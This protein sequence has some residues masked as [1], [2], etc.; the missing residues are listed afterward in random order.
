MECFTAI[1]LNPLHEAYMYFIGCLNVCLGINFQHYG[2]AIG[3][4]LQIFWGSII[5]FKVA[6][7]QYLPILEPC[8]L[9]TLPFYKEKLLPLPLLT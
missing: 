8:N 7:T 6:D 4:L 1:V 3:S 9:L 2:G 5:N